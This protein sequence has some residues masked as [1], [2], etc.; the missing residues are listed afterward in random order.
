MKKRI[1]IL[2]AV[3]L[4]VMIFT[5]CDSI[6]EMFFSEFGE[7]PNSL[8]LQILVDDSYNLV[9]YPVIIALIPYDEYDDPVQDA[10]IVDTI[11]DEPEIWMT[12]DGIPNGKYQIYVWFDADG[13]GVANDHLIGKPARFAVIDGTATV[14]LEFDGETDFFFAKCDLLTPPIPSDGP[15]AGA[16][17]D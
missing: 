9:D 11:Y 2:I 5:G 15:P 1:I 8:E 14:D 6:L 3:A 17:L 12:Y 7:N 10:I 13:D 16:G 4:S